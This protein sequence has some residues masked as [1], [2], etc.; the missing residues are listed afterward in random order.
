[1]SYVVHYL[2]RRAHRARLVRDVL[3]S[4]IMLGTWS[5]RLLP[6]EEELAAQHSVGRN[7]IRESLSMLVQENLLQRL[8][9][10]GTKPTSHIVVRRQAT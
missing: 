6:T 1:M 10:Q 7:V 4:E 5:N 8:P 3:R 2:S 9:G